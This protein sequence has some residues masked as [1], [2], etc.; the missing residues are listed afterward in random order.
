MC[1]NRQ[2]PSIG[3]NTAVCLLLDE[4][5]VICT[6]QIMYDSLVTFIQVVI[7]LLGRTVL[8]YSYVVFTCKSP[9]DPEGCLPSRSSLR[10]ATAIRHAF[11]PRLL[12]LCQM[13]V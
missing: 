2:T 6:K 12:S 1:M 10:L 5:F 11:E 4:C 13:G 8:K 9:A 3:A 7:M